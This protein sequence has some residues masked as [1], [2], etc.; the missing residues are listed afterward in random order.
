M[1]RM[2]APA[3]AAVSGKDKL[4]GP[5][6]PSHLVLTV[7]IGC[8]LKVEREGR[9]RLNLKSRALRFPELC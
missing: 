6:A 4:I 8:T 9:A 2:A 3:A 5:V 7:K 1:P